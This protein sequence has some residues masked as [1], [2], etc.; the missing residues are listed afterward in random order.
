MATAPTIEAPR[1][2]GGVRGAAREVVRA[3][4]TTRSGEGLLVRPWREFTGAVRERTREGVTRFREAWQST[5]DSHGILSRVRAMRVALRASRASNPEGGLQYLAASTSAAEPKA[6]SLAT[7]AANTSSQV[8]RI[9]EQTPSDS[10]VATPATEAGTPPAGEHA[11]AVPTPDAN[12]SASPSSPDAGSVPAAPTERTAS[13]AAQPATEP[14][15]AGGPNEGE[16]QPAAKPAEAAPQSGPEAPKP[17]DATPATA[18]PQPG[19]KPP[20]SQPAASQPTEQQQA[21]AL[22][23]ATRQRL[24]DGIKVGDIPL[25]ITD[26]KD[27]AQVERVFVEGI[28]RIYQEIQPGTNPTEAQSL[29]IE[30]LVSLAQAAGIS[31]ERLAAGLDGVFYRRDKDGNIVEEI[32]SPV[33]GIPAKLSLDRVNELKNKPPEEGEVTPAQRLQAEAARVEAMKKIIRNAQKE[34]KSVDE[35][36][37]RGE[38][39]STAMPI[40]ERAL[41]GRVREGDRQNIRTSVLRASSDDLALLILNEELVDQEDTGSQRKTRSRLLE[42]IAKRVKRHPNYKRQLKEHPEQLPQ[43]I[44][45][46]QIAAL[47]ANK[48]TLK[49][50]NKEYRKLHSVVG[51]LWRLF[52]LI[53][54]STAYQLVMDQ[55]GSM[56]QGQV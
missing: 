12:P 14:K 22:Q 36:I 27:S 50:V 56:S 48:E 49:K 45:R 1:P 19:Q 17:A 8:P 3:A 11:S 20:E 4:F 52:G 29:Q 46:E 15:P 55:A 43:V 23:E 6:P 39:V 53:A 35:Q 28:G 40:L 7:E 44:A 33:R 51:I 21:Q 16:A 13:P 10:A 41:Q 37:S 32:K 47:L 30:Y 5:S 18:P 26:P 25:Q 9:G 42:R 24:V 31:P 54:V 38:V 34:R 2:A